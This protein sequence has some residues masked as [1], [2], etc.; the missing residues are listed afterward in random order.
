[1]GGSQAMTTT[2]SRWP[3]AMLALFLAS[4]TLGFAADAKTPAASWESDLLASR[5][6]GADAG[7]HFLGR[8]QAHRGGGAGPGRAALWSCPAYRRYAAIICPARRLSQGIAGRWRCAC[9]SA[10]SRS[11]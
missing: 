11:R 6:P 5:A 8:S 2:S 1:M 9:E 4:V 10:E 7:R 3:I